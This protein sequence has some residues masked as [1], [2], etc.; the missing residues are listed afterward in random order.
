MDAKEELPRIYGFVNGG[1]PR[2]LIA[3]AIAEDGTV[4]CEHCSSNE[5]WAE[6]DL[7]MG[8]MGTNKR[9]YYEEHYPQGYITEF[10]PH[11]K[12]KTHEKLQAAIRKA[13]DAY[14][15]AHPSDQPEVHPGHEGSP[16]EPRA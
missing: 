15:K 13:Q 4:I 2:F 6:N 12:V 9:Q 3:V 5:Y 14:A 11:E 1:A 16:V 8:P 7:G 10:V